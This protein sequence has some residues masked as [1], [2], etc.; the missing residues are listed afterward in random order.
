MMVPARSNQVKSKDSAGA[1]DVVDDDLILMSDKEFRNMQQ[2][3][4]KSDDTA[5]DAHS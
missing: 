4:N 5:P 3:L 2:I 1:P